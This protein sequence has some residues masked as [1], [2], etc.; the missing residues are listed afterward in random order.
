MTQR[1][2]FDAAAATWDEKPQRIK[3]AAEIMAAMTACLSFSPAW[4]V[5]DLGCG[6]GLVTLR[7]APLVRE[8]VAV[9][10]SPGMLEK[11]NDKVRAAGWSNIR[12][13]QCDLE[14]DE[15]PD[16][17]FDL[18]TAAML[19]HHIPDPPRLVAALRQRLRP[20]GR[21]ALADLDREDGSFHEDGTGVFH[22]GFSRERFTSLLTGAGFGRISVTPAAEIVKGERRYPVLLAVGRR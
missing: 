10:G 12:T 19:L 16:G 21:L 13:L 22:H 20:G 11:L 9:D 2:N 7:L 14:R 18:I 3:L 15:L 6:T 5:M 4:R 17:P 8:V 1:R